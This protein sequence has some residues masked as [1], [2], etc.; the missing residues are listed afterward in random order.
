LREDIFLP[1]SEVE[2]PNLTGEQLASLRAYEAEVR[3]AIGTSAE[4]E[5]LIRAYRDGNRPV[6]KVGD[7][8]PAGISL[9]KFLVVAAKRD[10]QWYQA[11]ISKELPDGKVSLRFSGSR[12]DATLPRSDLRLPPPQ[13]KQ[14][15]VA[16]PFAAEATAAGRAA[17]VTATEF[18]TWTDSSGTF[19]IEARFV[20]HLGESIRLVRKDGKEIVVLLARLS[21]SDRQFAGQ[22]AKPTNPFNP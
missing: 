8:L 4:M 22:L 20:E 11:H 3:Q 13:V 9:P 6:P 10:N 15:N 1:P 17:M 7:P 12:F 19:K 14:P 5:M 21:E 2:Q 16:S 18:R